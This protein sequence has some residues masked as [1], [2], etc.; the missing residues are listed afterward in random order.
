MLCHYQHRIS[1]YNVNAP[2]LGPS[3]YILMVHL[4]A[5]TPTVTLS[6]ISESLSNGLSVLEDFRY[7]CVYPK[8]FLLVELTSLHIIQARYGRMCCFYGL[9]L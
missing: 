1:S 7:T 8:S 4:T 9:L 5:L 2:L 6:P 3:S